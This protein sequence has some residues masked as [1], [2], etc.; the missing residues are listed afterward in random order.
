DEMIAIDNDR[1]IYTMDDA[2]SAPGTF[3]WTMRWGPPVWTG[4]GFT[5]PTG[6]RSWAWSVV[7]KLEDGTLPDSAGYDHPVGDGKVSHIWTLSTDGQV[8]TFLDPWLPRDQSYQMCG[9]QRGRFRSVAMSA[10]GSTIFIMGKYG[11]MYTRLFDFDI[12]GDDPIFYD[13]T[14]EDQHGVAN[15]KVQLPAES[16][17]H[18]PKIPGV[19]TDDISI[20]KVGPKGLHRELRV[21]GKDRT[22]RIGFWS[23]DILAR[24]W[25]F[26]RAL[27][28]LGQAVANPAGDNSALNLGKSGNRTYEGHSS[29]ATLSIPNFNIYCSPATVNVTLPEGAHFSMLLHT[30][31]SIRQGKRAAGLDS[32]P[33]WVPGEFQVPASVRNSKNAEIRKFLASLGSGEWIKADLDATADH[34]K[35]R[36]Q[37]W[38]LTNR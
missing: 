17:R 15:P 10:S 37:K 33:R 24:T 28:P 13:Y 9:P 26:Q 31:D 25:S 3:N 18:Q 7:S 36:A 11:D 29:G 27:T 20:E 12:S 32:E 1:W 35:F 34:L 4:S 23:K 8:L 16:W 19:I 21:A 22:G 6:I 5:L 30:T 14:Y 38:I 2:L